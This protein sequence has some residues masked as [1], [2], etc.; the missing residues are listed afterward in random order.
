MNGT[1]YRVLAVTL[2]PLQQW[3]S[4]PHLL[5]WDRDKHNQQHPACRK[6]KGINQS[7]PSSYKIKTNKKHRSIYSQNIQIYASSQSRLTQAIYQTRNEQY[8]ETLNLWKK[9]PQI[10]NPP[11]NNMLLPHKITINKKLPNKITILRT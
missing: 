8:F 9:S 2:M 5:G 6:S 10:W 3:P 7:S 4:Y 1:I 11:T